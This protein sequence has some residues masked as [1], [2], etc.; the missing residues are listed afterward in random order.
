MLGSVGAEGLREGGRPGGLRSLGL[1]RC[2]LHDVA[3]TLYRRGGFRPF[4]GLVLLGSA[5]LQVWVFPPPSASGDKRQEN[6]AA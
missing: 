3:R 6:V 1:G 5:A 2:R 4:L